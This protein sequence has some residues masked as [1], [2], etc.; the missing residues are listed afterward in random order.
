MLNNSHNDHGKVLFPPNSLQAYI[1]RWDAYLSETFTF[2]G[3]SEL[4]Q[5]KNHIKHFRFRDRPNTVS[6]NDQERQKMTDKLK[7]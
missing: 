2:V 3:I 7:N 6:N 4:P 1:S 5:N